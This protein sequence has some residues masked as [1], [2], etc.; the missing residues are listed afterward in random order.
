MSLN[1]TIVFITLLSGPSL[2]GFLKSFFLKEAIE[3]SLDFFSW[4]HFRKYNILFQKCMWFSKTEELLN[5]CIFR[6]SWH[7][8]LSFMNR[9]LTKRK[10]SYRILL[11][12]FLFFTLVPNCLQNLSFLLNLFMCLK[13]MT[14]WSDVFKLVFLSLYVLVNL[15]ASLSCNA[16]WNV[17]IK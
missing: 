1:Y 2:L 13:T 16:V 11:G 4:L 17:K 7:L 10:H 8:I 3:S 9:F 5:N 14:F 6:G 15:E 12:P